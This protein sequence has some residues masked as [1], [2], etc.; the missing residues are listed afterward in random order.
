[1]VKINV[2]IGINN[3]LLTSPMNDAAVLTIAIANLILL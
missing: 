1:M 3:V 2:K